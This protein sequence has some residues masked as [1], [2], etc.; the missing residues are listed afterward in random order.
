MHVTSW[1]LGMCEY[2]LLRHAHCFCM[3]S[4]KIPHVLSIFLLKFYHS[5]IYI[6][7]EVEDGNMKVIYYSDFS[8]ACN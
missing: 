3:I 8:V 2:N 1:Q 7:V 4:M 6:E 5:Y